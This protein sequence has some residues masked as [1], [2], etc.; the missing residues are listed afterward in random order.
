MA[1]KCMI[2]ENNAE[3]EVKGGSAF[4]C[5]ECAK[6]NFSDISFL[7]KVEEQAQKLKKVLKERMTD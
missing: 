2:C 4:Y 7:I 6:E 1:K 5:E 3:Y